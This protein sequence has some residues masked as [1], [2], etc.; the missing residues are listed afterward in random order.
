MT[1]QASQY[2]TPEHAD[3]RQFCNGKDALAAHVMCVA[4]RDYNK[5][6]WDILVECHSIEEVKAA[7]GNAYTLHGAERAVWVKLVRDHYLARRE[8]RAEAF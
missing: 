6:G 8:V 7:I 3:Y 5:A 2:K 1:N 4:H